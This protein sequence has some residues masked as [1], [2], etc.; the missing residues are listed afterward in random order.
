MDERFT[1][2]KHIDN[3][4]A[5]VGAGIGIMRRMKPFIPVE[6]L[7]LIYNA[8]VQTYFDYCSPLWDNCGSGLRKSFKDCRTTATGGGG[9]GGEEKNFP[10]VP[11]RDCTFF[12][13]FFLKTWKFPNKKGTF[14]VNLVFTATLACTKRALFVTKKGTFH[15][16][17]GHF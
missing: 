10:V 12:T 1:W 4:R 16:K 5:K 2:E 17:K 13:K 7:K 11:Y 8:L 3:I 9:G 15:H 6:T 14:G